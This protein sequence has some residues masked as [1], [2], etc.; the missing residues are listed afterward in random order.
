MIDGSLK[1][2]TEPMWLLSLGYQEHPLAL[3]CRESGV[4]TG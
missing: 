1:Y 4:L 3:R 2:V